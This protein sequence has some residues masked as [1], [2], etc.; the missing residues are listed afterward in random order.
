MLRYVRKELGRLL[1]D[2]IFILSVLCVCLLNLTNAV[3]YD[4]KLDQN[5]MAFSMLTSSYKDLLKSSAEYSS[6]GIFC[7][8]IS[9]WVLMF[10]P[11]LASMPFI[12]MLQDEK[13]NRTDRAIISREKKKQ[14]FLGNIIIAMLSGALV[15]MCGYLL[16]GILVNILFPGFGSY[17]TELVQ[18]YID[19][20][21]G[22]PEWYIKLLSGKHLMLVALARL[23]PAF[24]FGAVIALPGFFLTVITNNG[25]VCVSMPFFLVYAWEE[26]M[27]WLTA[28]LLEKPTEAHIKMTNIIYNSRVFSIMNSIDNWANIKYAVRTAVIVVLFFAA[29]YYIINRFKRSCIE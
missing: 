25:F 19:N 4:Y 13:E 22:R 24:V 11:V 8:G 15:M 27:E 14:Y 2:R 23:V 26:V 17:S 18:D 7:K 5:V 9:S 29:G 3:A 28:S 1:C 20:M 21:T 16:Y 10:S 6:I 12:I